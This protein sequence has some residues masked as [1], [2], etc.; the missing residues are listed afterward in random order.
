MQRY[1]YLY[2]IFALILILHCQQVVYANDYD[3]GAFINKELSY[4]DYIFN[5]TAG[6][7]NKKIF[8]SNLNC[9]LNNSWGEFIIG[10]QKAKIG[11][12]YFAQLILSDNSFPL[13][14]VYHKNKYTLEN[15]YMEGEQLIAFLNSNINRQL[16]I[17]RI[18]TDILYPGLE[19]GLSESLM[20]FNKIHPSYYIP[21]PYWPY[22]LSKKMFAIH[23]EYDWYGDNYIGIDFKY[24]FD[25]NAKIY[26]EILVDEFPMASSHSHPD[27]R[28]HLIGIYYPINNNIVLRSEFSN[29]HSYTYTHRYSENNY[30]YQEKPIGHWLGSDGDV[31]DIEIENIVSDEFAYRYG[32][33]YVRHGSINIFDEYEDSYVFKWYGNDIVKRDILIRMGLDQEFSNGFSVDLTAELG[34]TFSNEKA[35]SVLNIDMGINIDL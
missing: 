16:F 26:G 18:S 23:N 35:D 24:R 31:F 29:V 10:R 25:N 8:F 20:V 1:K 22:Y 5:I 19:V 14:M 21:L 9:T 2:I 12:G 15:G 34:R 28:A 6:L 4:K 32:L 7:N 30:V 3:V 13:D 27:K 11:P 17:H 33:R